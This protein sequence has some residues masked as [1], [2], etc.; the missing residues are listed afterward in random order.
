MKKTLISILMILIFVGVSYADLQDGIITCLPF[1]DGYVPSDATDL[2]DWHNNYTLL[3]DATTDTTCAVGD[4]CIT[5]DGTNDYLRSNKTSG[6]G[7]DN[8]YT[9]S[10]W[11]QIAADEDDSVVFDT[12]DTS[13]DRTRLLVFNVLFGDPTYHKYVSFNV[14]TATMETISRAAVWEH[15]VI[16]YDTND[17]N[18]TLFLNATPIYSEITAG[19]MALVNNSMYFGLRSALDRDM[20]GLIDEVKIWNRP[21]T[22][23]EISQDY[24]SS[25]G[26][27]C[28]YLFDTPSSEPP[29]ISLST[30]LSSGNYSE[31]S[32]NFTF[33]SSN[34]NITTDSFNCTFYRDSVANQTLE[35]TAINM[36]NQQF[37]VSLVGVEQNEVW[38]V[39]C[40]KYQG[41]DLV[42]GSFVRYLSIDTVTPDIEQTSIVNNSVFYHYVD[43]QLNMTISFDD[44]NLYAINA[45]IYQLNADGSRNTTF[46]NTFVDSITGTSFELNWTFGYHNFTSAR[47]EVE[48][49]AWDSHTTRII[50]DYPW[51][52][53]SVEVGGTTYKGISFN[54]NYLNISSDDYAKI[55][56]FAL[57]KR[58]D[59]YIFAFNLTD[60]GHTYS[61][62]LDS[63]KGI[64]YLQDSDYK[65]HFIIGMKHW[66]DFESD[67]VQD[68]Q[69][70]YI[71][72]YDVYRVR[73][74]PLKNI[75]VFKSIGDLNTETVKWYFN[76]T[77]GFRFYAKDAF[78]NAS[79]SNFTIDVFNGTELVQSR[80]T[81]S[82]IVAF[83]LTYGNYTTNFSSLSHATNQTFIEFSQ[84]GTFTYS[85][86][87]TNSLYLFVY[88]EQTDELLT[89]Q[90]ATIKI[91]N[92]NVSSVEVDT[93]AGTVFQSG[94]QPGVYELRYW[95]QGYN[96][97]S[98]YVSI[99]NST[100]QQIDLYLLNSSEATYTSFINQDE[101]GNKYEGAY[102]KVLRHFTD[103][104]CFKV[105]EMDL[106]NF[107]GVATLSLEHY[108]GKYSFL[109]EYGGTTVY[110]ST[111][112]EGYVLSE[113]AYT[114]TW[115]LLGDTTESFF[116]TSGL[117][118]NV[119][120]SNTTKCFY[121]T[122]ND[123]SN[124]VDQFCLYVDEMDLQ[125]ATGYTRRCSSCLNSSSGTITCNMT[126][127]FAL[128]HELVARPWIHTN[129]EYSE[130]WANPVSVITNRTAIDTI[131]LFG[132]FLAFL[133]VVSG[134]FAGLLI[135]GL[136]GAIIFFDVALISVMFIKLVT[137]TLPI[138]IGIIAVSVIVLFLVGDV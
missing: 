39:T 64:Q 59:R 65:G 37:N 74:Q 119:T 132:V 2:S 83:N 137:L 75:V 124:L 9:I 55:Q 46:N 134:F 138:G 76:V 18:F 110:A 77:D 38:N 12:G 30:S 4:G 98:Y 81:E 23:A 61:I 128:G 66:I 114:L 125:A 121:Y 113:N 120:W 8:S 108:V 44:T 33:N 20:D 53:Y 92:F 15:M 32:F 42:I 80:S 57:V 17:N 24:N 103:C 95:A 88:D 115:V 11:H 129:T 94:F 101:T 60:L 28:V 47:Y 96:M 26:L 25:S 82:G 43:D 85:V 90:N 21:I 133:I 14:E 70:D 69:I 41:S 54:D 102:V 58:D 56:D 72:Q 35:N 100:T 62:F 93:A 36:T 127:Y 122:L 27:S 52:K 68:L 126:S 117:Y 34:T 1:D 116:G 131:G 50:S 104:N 31:D 91:T 63:K 5:F 111:A 13:S 99:S 135:A 89:S 136:P 79:V 78:T 67:D 87:A 106:T 10:L 107:N 105:V 112:E 45:S 71:P 16:R 7:G 118:H 29:A 86:F 73:F 97:R 130:Y 48:A 51:E 3:G 123:P 40:S 84:N 22:D 109:V 6:L 19:A 49:V